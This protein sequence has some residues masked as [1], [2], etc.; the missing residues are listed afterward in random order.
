M[1]EAELEYHTHQSSAVF[2]GVPLCSNIENFASSIGKEIDPKFKQYSKAPIKAV[3]WTTTPWSLPANAAIAY[4][5]NILYTLVLSKDS[6]GHTFYIIANDC[7]PRVLA[8]VKKN[9]ESVVE[10][11]GKCYFIIYFSSQSKNSISYKDF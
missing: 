7:L 2:V 5:E 1:A 6:D 10:F 4:N 11:K 8:S 9:F 3:F